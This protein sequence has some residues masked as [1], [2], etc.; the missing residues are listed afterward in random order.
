V[1]LDAFVRHPRVRKHIGVITVFGQW[2]SV[3]AWPSNSFSTTPWFLLLLLLLLLSFFLTLSDT[4][5]G[6]LSKLPF[7]TCISI[8][9]NFFFQ[10]C[11]IPFLRSEEERVCIAWAIAH[12]WCLSHEFLFLPRN[13]ILQLHYAYVDSFENGFPPLSSTRNEAGERFG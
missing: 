2:L 3:F 8:N 6:A 10:D 5:F 11:M 12:E 4:R 9:H 7:I 1:A 13:H